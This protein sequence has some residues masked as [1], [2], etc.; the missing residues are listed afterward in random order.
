MNITNSLTRE[1]AWSCFRIW[2]KKGM[3]D[4]LLAVQL[5]PYCSPGF[6]ILCSSGAASVEFL[7]L[8]MCT[9]TNL[10]SILICPGP[11]MWL[12]CFLVKAT[13]YFCSGRIEPLHLKCRVAAGRLHGI[14]CSF[15]VFSGN[16]TWVTALREPCNM[17]AALAARSAY[18]AI[19]GCVPSA[20]MEVHRTRVLTYSIGE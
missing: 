16:R 3:P 14:C 12:T 13:F 5:W 6:W 17:A 15:V 11:F 8:G 7:C 4:F 20:Y 1:T 2:G 10:I 9:S 18:T 19:Q